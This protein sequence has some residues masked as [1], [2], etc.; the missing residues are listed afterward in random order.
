M[1]PLLDG[2]GDDRSLEDYITEVIDSNERLLKIKAAERLRGNPTSRDIW[3]DVLQE[4]RLVQMQVIRKRP[5]ATSQYVHAAM[6][7]R[8]SEVISRGAWTGSE[9]KRGHP[10]DPLRRPAERDSLDDPDWDVVISSGDWVE[11]VISGYHDGEI[12]QALDALTF[13]QKAHVVARIWYGLS[14]PEIAAM[15]H[16]SVSTVSRRWTQDIRPQLVRRLGHLIDL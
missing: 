14:E 5:D 10:I 4:G 6:S 12:A 1:A 13:T 7:H 3:D 15:Q 2:F 11:Q 9:A 16:V 8:M